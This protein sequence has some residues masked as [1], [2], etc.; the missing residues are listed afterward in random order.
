MSGVVDDPGAVLERFRD[1]LRLLARLQL[2]A[3]LRG[4]MDPS[5]LVQETLLRAYKGLD[6]F[7]GRSLAEQ[8][9]WLRQILAHTLANA[10]R[11]YSSQ[12][13]DAA[14]ELS[15]QQALADSSSR[16]EHLLAADQPSPSQ[17][18]EHNE[19]MLR[20]A[21]ALEALPESQREALLLRYTQGLSV[22]EICQQLGRSRASV[23]SLL[24]RGLQQL[25]VQLAQGE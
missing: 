17:Q 24:R 21:R 1:Y 11:E 18:A 22:P 25:R 19:Q 16:L 3:R 6:E 12:K 8:T 7:R 23:A 20:L 2:P 14:L 9:V 15:L 10:I 4:K 5:D 13:R